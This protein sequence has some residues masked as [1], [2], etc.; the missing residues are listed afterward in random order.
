MRVVTSIAFVFAILPATLNAQAVDTAT[1]EVVPG[2]THRRTVDARGPFIINVLRV[3]LKRSDIEVRHARARD[4]LK[5]RE[6]TSEMARRASTD[7]VTVI[8]ALN[9][10]FFDLRTGENE[11][12]QVIAR[13]WWKGVKVT[14]SPYDTYDNAHIQFALDTARRP[15]MDR[16][17][18]DGRAWARNVMT[19]IITLNSNPA[20]NPEGTAFYTSRYGATTPRDTTRQTAEAPLVAVGRRADTLLFLRQGTVALTSGSAIPPNGA[21]LSAYGTGLRRT[22][23]QA[24]AEGDTIKVLLGTMPRLSTPAA[25][26]IGGWPRILRDGEV[27]TADAPIVEGTI[28]RNAEV[29]HPR[30]AVG[31]S[32]DSTTLFLVTV[33]GRSERSVGMTL[34]ELATFMRDLG[35]SN[36]M[37]FDG[38][39]STTMVVNGA[40][41]NSPADAAG[42]REVGNA[43]LIVKRH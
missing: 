11:N 1:R 27:V 35:A 22:E 16:F 19:P 37:N 6:K 4:Q 32:R 17:L 26:I 13:E 40:I 30:T 10:D 21:V 36:A 41:V 38:G 42:E 39:G 20:G 23:V 18:F 9:A 33:D 5:G 8:A 2:V 43:L 34:T 15:F 25:L 3:D 7:S 28:S 31:F 12:N 14:D 29:R 24:M